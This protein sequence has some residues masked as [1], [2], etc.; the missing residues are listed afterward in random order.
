MSSD[1]AMPITKHKGLEQVRTKRKCYLSVYLA[2]V[3][4]VN[5]V[6]INTL[7]RLISLYLVFFYLF[8]FF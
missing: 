3:A 5:S 4:K 1:M 8:I 7:H 2:P 6:Y